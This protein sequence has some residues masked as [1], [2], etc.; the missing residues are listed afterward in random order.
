[1]TIETLG[2]YDPSNVEDKT[3][4]IESLGEYLTYLGIFDF[5]M[6]DTGTLEGEMDTEILAAAQEK[7]VALLPVITNL[8]SEGDFDRDLAYQVLSNPETLEVFIGNILSLL[9]ED[10]LIGVII[11]IENLNPEDRNVFTNFIQK[12]YIQ[13]KNNNKLLILNM[14]AK[15]DDW[16]NEEWVG[17]FDYNALG[18]SIDRAAIMTY[19]FG[20]RSGPPRATVPLRYITRSLDYAIENNIP[21]NK[22]LLGL[23]LYGYDWELPDNPE[24]LATAVTLPEVWELARKYRA[25]I[26]F[27]DFEQQAFMDYIRNGTHHKVWFEDAMG[28]FLKYELVKSYGLKGVFYWLISMP[29]PAT[30]YMVSRLFR[31]EK[32]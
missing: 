12:L 16:P 23:T 26:Q 28:H 19:E 10:N 8:N 7:N 24:N 25:S 18:D 21:A 5:K 17:F 1:P 6:T 22:I 20:W 11:D 4:L 27:D 32:L 13:L 14:P 30:W 31:I 29:F 15:W 9:N 3:A 2:Y